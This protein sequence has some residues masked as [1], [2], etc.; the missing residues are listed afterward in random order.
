[1][2]ELET[3][4][5]RGFKQI[6]RSKRFEI[7]QHPEKDRLYINIFDPPSREEVNEAF[8]AIAGSFTR[9]VDLI[10]DHRDMTLI[11]EAQPSELEICFDEFF[12]QFQIRYTVRVC[13]GI[14][15]S[16]QICIPLD[17]RLS[18]EKKGRL[19]GRTATLDEADKLLDQQH[20][21]L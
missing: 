16:C 12:E 1:M 19:L 5:A 15:E 7:W 6:H 3:L 8:V 9:P 17:V 10:T 20:G 18:K 21:Q 2:P 11:E 4:K 13:G 14:E